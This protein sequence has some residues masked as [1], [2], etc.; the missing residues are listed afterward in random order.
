MLKLF[1][2]SLLKKPWEIYKC[3]HT[4]SGCHA[5]SEIWNLESPESRSPGPRTHSF[6]HT[7]CR[8]I[9]SEVKSDNTTLLQDMKCWGLCIIDNKINH[10]LFI[11]FLSCWAYFVDFSVSSNNEH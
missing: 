5:S 10:W 6:I 11:V 1:A 8:K 2:L 4:L 7:K 3:I 9:K